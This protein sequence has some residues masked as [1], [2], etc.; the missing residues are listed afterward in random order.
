LIWGACFAGRAQRPAAA[1]RVGKRARAG[2]Q[3][4]L[5]L[6]RFGLGAAHSVRISF[7]KTYPLPK[8]TSGGKPVQGHGSVAL[9]NPAQG[10]FASKKCPHMF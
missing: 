7:A 3:M 6:S 1:Q 9:T 2:A 8:R 10:E 5:R 4:D